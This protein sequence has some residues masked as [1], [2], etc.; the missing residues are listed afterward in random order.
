MAPE[1]ALAKP[2]DQRADIYAFGLILYD[3]LLGRR[4]ASRAESAVAELMKRIQQAP[5]PPRSIDPMIPEAV[6]KSS[7]GASTRRGRALSDRGGAHCRPRVD[8]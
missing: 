8:R 1:Q 7:S 2:V 4:Q 6:D 5:P 3:M